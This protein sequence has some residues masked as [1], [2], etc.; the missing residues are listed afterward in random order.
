MK[1][2]LNGRKIAYVLRKA[3]FSKREKSTGMII[4][5]TSCDGYDLENVLN[6]YYTLSYSKCNWNADTTAEVKKMMDALV[7]AGYECRYGS[8]LKDWFYIE[9]YNG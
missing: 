7:E 6:E 2:N 5:T 8:D 4:S 1:N 3:G 9:S